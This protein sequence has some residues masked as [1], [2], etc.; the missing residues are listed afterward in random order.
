MTRIQTLTAFAAFAAVPGA[1]QGQAAPP[2]IKLYVLDLGRLESSN[3]K[4]LTDRGVTMTDMSVVAYLIV[5]PRG[6]L[7]WDSGTIPDA[8][9][10]SVVS[11]TPPTYQQ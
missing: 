11:A 1:A 10:P 5:H 6:T 8:P 4:P 2:A 9:G 3:P 7:L